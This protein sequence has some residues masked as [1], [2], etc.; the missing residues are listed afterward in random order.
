MWDVLNHWSL[1]GNPGCCLPWPP[2]LKVSYWKTITWD[3]LHSNSKN[4]NM[5]ARQA[6]TWEKVHVACTLFLKG[7]STECMLRELKNSKSRGCYFLSLFFYFPAVCSSFSPL[8]VK[9]CICILFDS[10]WLILL[11]WICLRDF[12]T[13]LH[14]KPPQEPLVMSSRLFLP[15][16][17]KSTSF[18]LW[19]IP[20]SWPLHLMLHW[21]VA[22]GKEE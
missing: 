12:Q 21:S 10:P 2:L 7:A 11:P 20:A 14:K 8:S 6:S 4:I 13:H 22:V 17:W 3:E 15:A 9:S 1:A 16:V 19:F 18:S 5:Q